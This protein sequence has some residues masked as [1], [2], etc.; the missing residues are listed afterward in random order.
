MLEFDHQ[1]SNFQHEIVL[2]V[3][4]NQLKFSF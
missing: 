4:K 2:P 1:K 3:L